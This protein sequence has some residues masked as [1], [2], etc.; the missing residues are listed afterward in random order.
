[1]ERGRKTRSLDLRA[2]SEK[3]YKLGMSPTDRLTRRRSKASFIITMVD[4]EDDDDEEEDEDEDDAS[5]VLETRS[6]SRFAKL[7][8]GGRQTTLDWRDSVP[9]CTARSW[10][11][12]TSVFEG[13]EEEDEEDVFLSSSA[14]SF[15]F[16]S[17]A[18][19]PVAG[20]AV[21]GVEEAS[22][23]TAAANFPPEPKVVLPKPFVEANEVTG[24][25]AVPAADVADDDTLAAAAV[26]ACFPLAA[27]AAAASAARCAFAS[28]SAELMCTMKTLRPNTRLRRAT[29]DTSVRRH[30]C[31]CCCWSVVA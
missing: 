13:E 30:R 21:E 16:P 1:M 29:R 22:G 4:D 11:W 18:T 19:A 10:R 25:A 24:F 27:L 7:D 15:S 5:F 28:S 20:A 2:H 9:N 6:R 3:M 23:F 12:S 26:A 31:C 14:A 8:R 17:A